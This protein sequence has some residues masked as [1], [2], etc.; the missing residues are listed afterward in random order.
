MPVL[1]V[2][3]IVHNYTCF[4]VQVLFRCNVQ[5]NGHSH[6]LI[7]TFFVQVLFRCTAFLPKSWSS[8]VVG[9]NAAK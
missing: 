2:Y 4:C 3:T 8:L 1:S 7:S 6:V 5:D 9:T